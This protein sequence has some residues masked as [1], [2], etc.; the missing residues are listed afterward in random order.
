MRQQL[1]SGPGF[2]DGIFRERGHGCHG[3]EGLHQEES[4]G[5]RGKV[6]LAACIAHGHSQL[7]VEIKLLRNRLA[8]SQNIDGLLEAG[9][10]LSNPGQLQRCTCT[11]QQPLTVTNYTYF[12]TQLETYSNPFAALT[13]F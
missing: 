9:V 2:L 7:A 6:I 5:S 10:Q 4:H 1:C 13:P 3:P 12:W 8:T 11:E